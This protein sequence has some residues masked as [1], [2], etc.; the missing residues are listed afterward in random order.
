N[1]SRIFL[2]HKSISLPLSLPASSIPRYELDAALLESARRSG[3]RVEEDVAVRAV[4]QTQVGD[5]GL[6]KLKTT[7]G[8]FES[9]ALVNATGRWSQLTRHVA[10]SGDSKWIG[11]KAHFRE[12]SPPDSVDLYFF[13]GGYCGVQ[14]VGRDT[15]NAAAMVQAAAARSL[16]DVLAVHPQLW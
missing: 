6:F 14:K 1:S 2:D 5:G 4:D 12:A 10:R 11:L 13:S 7:N 9:R 15:V 8:S 3:A 16:D